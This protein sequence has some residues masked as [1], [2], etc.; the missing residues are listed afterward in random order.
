MKYRSSPL[1]FRAT[2]IAGLLFSLPAFLAYGGDAPANLPS[3]APAG[4]LLPVDAKTDAAWLAKARANY[5]L[6]RCLVCGDKLESGG[7][8]KNTEYIYRQAGQPDRL[9]RFC[10]DTDC[11]PSFKKEPGKYLQVIDDAT[12]TKAADPKK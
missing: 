8:G 6:T 3:P 2:F 12:A 5:P 1:P 9:V 10:D 11:V 4:V 7:D